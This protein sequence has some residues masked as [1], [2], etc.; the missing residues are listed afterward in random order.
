MKIKISNTFLISVFVI[1]VFASILN[2]REFKNFSSFFF[3]KDDEIFYKFKILKHNHY[4]YL[5]AKKNPNSIG[6]IKELSFDKSLKSFANKSTRAHVFYF[7]NYWGIE[8]AKELYKIYNE[9]VFRLPFLTEKFLDKNKINIYE[10][11]SEIRKSSFSNF[12]NKGIGNIGL[13]NKK[14]N[15]SKSLYYFKLQINTPNQFLSLITLDKDHKIIN[16][17]EINL[18]TYPHHKSDS[19]SNKIVNSSANII[20]LDAGS[21]NNSGVHNQVTKLWFLYYI[22]NYEDFNLLLNSYNS[23]DDFILHSDTNDISLEYK[24]NSENQNFEILEEHLKI[25]LCK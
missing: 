14:E 21:E 3:K 20:L 10:K 15:L 8:K 16:R 4:V 11:C 9:N 22:N 24:I 12:F 2:S 13:I 19:F 18:V 23:K 5:K 1:F 6:F 17:S 7:H 25:I